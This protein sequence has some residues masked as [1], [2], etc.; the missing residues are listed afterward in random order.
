MP[1]LTAE[2]MRAQAAVIRIIYPHHAATAEMLY[3]AAA[4]EE[5]LEKLSAWC[6]SA[7]DWQDENDLEFEAL[8]RRLG[9]WRDEASISQPQSQ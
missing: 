1:R 6:R 8:L 5:A 7:N 9:L 4:T 2:Q 3:Q